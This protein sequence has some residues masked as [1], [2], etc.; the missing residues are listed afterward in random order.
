MATTSASSRS[1]SPTSSEQSSS[2]VSSEIT[3]ER[4]QRKIQATIAQICSS[5]SHPFARL[6]ELQQA[7]VIKHVMV[8]DLSQDE[9]NTVQISA[10]VRNDK[11]FDSTAQHRSKKVAKKEAS[12]KVLDMVSKGELTCTRSVTKF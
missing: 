2:T 12:Q 5:G 8:E 9:K 7:R 11:R 4:I 3:A 1:A 6:Q 10:D